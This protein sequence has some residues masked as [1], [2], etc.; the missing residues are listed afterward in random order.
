MLISGVTREVQALRE[1]L[2]QRDKIML[3]LQEQLDRH[4]GRE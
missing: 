2:R 3:H 1:E 4:E